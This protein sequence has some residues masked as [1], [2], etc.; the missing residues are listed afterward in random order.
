MDLQP[1][2]VTVRSP[3]QPRGAVVV[4][5]GGGARGEAVPVSATS[6]RS[7]GWRRSPPG[8]PV[9]D[10]AGLAVLRLLN[11]ARGWDTAHTPVDDVTWALGETRS[12]LGGLP[13]CLVGHSLGGRAALLAA[14][15]HDGVCRRGPR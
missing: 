12:R 13:T 8:S 5:H 7:C 3:R 10:E 15:G 9:P 6:C 1:R 4:L 11:S 2:L 14:A